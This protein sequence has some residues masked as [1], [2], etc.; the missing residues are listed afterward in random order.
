MTTSLS[1][2]FLVKDENKRFAYEVIQTI[3]KRANRLHFVKQLYY[4]ALSQD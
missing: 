4:S 1:C 3:I 2:Q